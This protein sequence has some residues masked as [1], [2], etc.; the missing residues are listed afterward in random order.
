MSSKIVG[1]VYI[2]ALGFASLGSFLLIFWMPPLA[3]LILGVLGAIA[4]RWS[5]AVGLRPHELWGKRKAQLLVPLA[6]ISITVAFLA[7]FLYGSLNLD[8]CYHNANCDPDVL[9]VPLVMGYIFSLLALFWTEIACGLHY[10]RR[11]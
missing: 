8:R 5:A 2:F 1:A 10:L 4:V 7:I 11:R 6:S 3:L 9:T